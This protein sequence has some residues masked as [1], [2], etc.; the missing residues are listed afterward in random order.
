[1]SYKKGKKNR[2][3]NIQTIPEFFAEKSVLITGGTGFVGKVLIEKILRS[4]PEVTKIYLLIRPKGTKTLEDRTNELRNLPIFVK[5]KR[6]DENSL[7]K[8]VAIKGDVT[9][10]GLGISEEDRKLLI[11]E[12]SIV[13]HVAASVRFDDP[14]KKAILMN[15]RG[16]YEMVKLAQQMRILQSFVHVSTAY[17]NTHKEIIEEIVY[18]APADWREVIH[19]AE[20]M[21]QEALEVFCGK[22]LGFY[23]N[24]YTYT[25]ALAEHVVLDHADSI[26]AAIFRPTIVISSVVEPLPG[27]VDNFNGPVGLI[28]AGGKGLIRT[29]Y[30]DPNIMPDYIPV[31][32]AV[33]AMIT[34]A[35]N[36]A[37]SLEDDFS[38]L[39]VYNCS[40][41]DVKRITQRETIDLGIYVTQDVPFN[42][43]L[44]LPSTSVTKCR[45]N[46][47]ILVFFLHF[48]PALVFDTILKLLKKK[49][50][51]VKLQRKIF[52][53]NMALEYFLTRHWSFRHERLINLNYKIFEE[54]K[55]QFDYMLPADFDVM[56]YYRNCAY[57]ARQYLLHEDNV[58]LPEAKKHRLRMYW[59]DKFIKTLF[60]IFMVYLALKFQVVTS[61]RM[62]L[63][64]FASQL[65]NFEL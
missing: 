62:S 50:L 55:P 27:W 44:W 15:T 36:R 22:I 9:E 54:D 41:D 30:T 16:T 19:I 46:H 17:C 7:L 40:S 56:E 51:L 47:Y 6:Q 35:W 24:T 5:V 37:C 42:D 29:L 58:E 45:F 57:G 61:L 34:V 18:P 25:K 52:V 28:V 4:C 8:I 3:Y 43:I 1:M 63:T 12:V 14:L 32:F 33:R 65:T 31:D 38:Q 21:D 10:P 23:P 2:A 60:L 53:A 13:F 11:D 64:S 59:L 39:P 20:N 26:P 48:I 49:P